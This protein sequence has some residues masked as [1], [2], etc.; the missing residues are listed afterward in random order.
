MEWE[1][2]IFEPRQK[3]P[4]GRPEKNPFHTAEC[5]EDFI[6]RSM[7]MVE[8]YYHPTPGKHTDYELA[9][10]KRISKT[11]LWS[12]IYI[13]YLVEKGMDDNCTGFIKR[14]VCNLGNSVISDRPA[15]SRSIEKLQTLY[16]SIDDAQLEGMKTDVKIPYAK[17]K[18][19]RKYRSQYV[20][21][22]KRW[23]ECLG[24]K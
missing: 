9:P 6:R 1:D 22:V 12:M 15:L 21:V 2:D 19:R 11:L 18:A 3:R 7:A 20:Y 17:K 4:V 10:K 5:E 24:N 13:Y 8:M 23:E 16:L 14:V